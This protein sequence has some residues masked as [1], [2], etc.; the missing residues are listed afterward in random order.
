MSGVTPVGLKYWRCPR[1]PD[2]VVLHLCGQGDG[3]VFPGPVKVVVGAVA[4]DMN[5]SMRLVDEI[6]AAFEARFKQDPVFRMWNSAC[7]G[8]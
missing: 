2:K 7:A 4:T 1:N 6:S 5:Q 3:S 8:I